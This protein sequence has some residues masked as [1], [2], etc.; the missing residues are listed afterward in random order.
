MID[1]PEMALLLRY[2][3]K[4]NLIKQDEIEKF[5]LENGIKDI[6]I[7]EVIEYLTEDVQVLLKVES[8]FEFKKIYYIS[9]GFINENIIQ[10][11]FSWDSV[12]SLDV[13]LKSDKTNNN[14]LYIIDMMGGGKP[15]EIGII[16]EKI[17]GNSTVI[18][19]LMVGDKFIISHAYSRDYLTP[20]ILCLYD[21]VMDKVFM[22][23]QNKISSM[24]DVINHINE[25]YGIK[26]PG[27]PVSE[28]DL[29]YLMRELEQY[30]LTFKGDGRSAFTGC[31]IS[32][33]KIIN[34]NSLEKTSLCIPFSPKCDCLHHYHKQ[35]GFRNA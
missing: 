10:K 23:R 7:S 29:F 34:I 26:A 30:L 8:D 24:S 21:Y 22:D 28:L 5:W 31:D 35:K 17:G 11:C 4:Q 19:L 12:I 1:N 9:N 27:A 18:F 3:E 15:S 25:N 32:M 16:Q 20:C 33:S 13:F 6:D 14:A 2:I